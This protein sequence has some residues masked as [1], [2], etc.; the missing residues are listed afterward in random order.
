MKE[1]M[2]EWIN[3]KGISSLPPYNIT[4]YIYIW[5]SWPYSHIATSRIMHVVIIEVIYQSKLCFQHSSDT[6]HEDDNTSS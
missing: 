2:N 6:P 3:E 5:P 4:F 1:L